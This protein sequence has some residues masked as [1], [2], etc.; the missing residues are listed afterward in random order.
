[1]SANLTVAIRELTRFT[2]AARNGQSAPEF[3][4][5]AQGEL[6]LFKSELEGLAANSR[7]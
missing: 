5:P 7:S 4:F 6:A 1:M 3:T 2:H